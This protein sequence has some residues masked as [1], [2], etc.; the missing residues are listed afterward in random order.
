MLEF[1]VHGRDAYGNASPLQ[2]VDISLVST[3]SD[4]LADTALRQGPDVAT[5]VVTTR[6]LCEGELKCCSMRS[7]PTLALVI[8]CCK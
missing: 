4:A 2:P 5:V 8:A 7:I 1:E 6:V 3:P